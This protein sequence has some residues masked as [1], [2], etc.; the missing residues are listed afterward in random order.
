MTTKEQIIYESLKL[1][2][3]NGFDAV[4]TRMIA[5]TIHASDAVIYKHFKSKQEILDQIID[6]CCKRYQEKRD[7]VKLL[8]ICWKDVEDLCMGMFQ[9]QTSD[10]WIVNFRRLLIVEQY[11]NPKM[12]QLYRMI[13]IDGPIQSMTGMFQ[14][15]M[16]LGNM[17]KGN[18]EVYAMDLYGPFFLYHTFD[19]QSERLLNNLKEHVHL[20][21]V[22]VIT[23]QCYL[24]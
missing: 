13:F 14:E 2:A 20:F 9:F 12:G 23:D 21:R 22:N 11:K 15:L 19:C 4:S 6:I 24:E 16:K 18:P 17:K 5:K 10:E 7:A 3:V 1:F 8:N